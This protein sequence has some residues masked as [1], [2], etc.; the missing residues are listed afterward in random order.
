LVQRP[1]LK[2]S[3]SGHANDQGGQARVYSK[4]PVEEN[5]KKHEHKKRK[6]LAYKE[7]KNKNKKVF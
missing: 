2:H 7:R 4:A 6:E 5:K 1:G 3:H